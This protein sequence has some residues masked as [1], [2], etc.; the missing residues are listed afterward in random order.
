MAAELLQLRESDAPWIPHFLIVLLQGLLQHHR[1]SPLDA[2]QL[3]EGLCLHLDATCSATNTAEVHSEAWTALGKL[4]L[5][6]AEQLL[7]SQADLTQQ[8]ANLS[9]AQASDAAQNNVDM[10]LEQDNG[11][12]GVT[13]PADTARPMAA[14]VAVQASSGQ[15]RSGSKMKH[16]QTDSQQLHSGDRHMHASETSEAGTAASGSSAHDTVSG[17]PSQA[18]DQGAGHNSQPWAGSDAAAALQQWR[19]VQRA[20]TPRGRWWAAQHFDPSQLLAFETAMQC[21]QQSLQ[22]N[23][24]V[25]QQQQQ[26]VAHA[27]SLAHQ[28]AVAMCLMGVDN[29]FVGRLA[30]AV[31]VPGFE[32][33]ADLVC[34]HMPHMHIQPLCVGTVFCANCHK[35]SMQVAEIP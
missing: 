21:S 17:R 33:A 16:A 3:A 5:S 1:Q 6:A 27:M 29:G 4:L 20:L 31:E 24:S 34:Q 30:E 9:P 8:S 35:S 15:V 22:E 32:A 25:D 23:G 12:P 18:S 28:A 2:A 19:A 11:P 10:A 14:A 26:L 13:M 7:T